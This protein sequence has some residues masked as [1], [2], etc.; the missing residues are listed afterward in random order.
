MKRF[1]YEFRI[2]YEKI[3]ILLIKL[4]LF[5]QLM[6]GPIDCM[7]VDVKPHFLN[8]ITVTKSNLMILLVIESP[9]PG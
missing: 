9:H 5:F 7:R 2:R 8:I 3:L 4:D 1:A 6:V